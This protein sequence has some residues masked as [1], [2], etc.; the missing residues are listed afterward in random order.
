MT[1]VKIPLILK[2]DVIR[3]KREEYLDYKVEITIF[4]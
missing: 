2:F 4:F 1:E 3:F